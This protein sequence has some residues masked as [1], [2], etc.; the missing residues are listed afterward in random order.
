MIKANDTIFKFYLAMMDAYEEFLSEKYPECNCAED[1]KH[2]QTIIIKKIVRM[3][4]SLELLTKNTL[5]E[6]STRCI[7]RGIL[8]SVT[9]YCFIYQR[10][11]LEDIMFRHYLYTLDG[12]REYKR[13]GIGLSEENEYKKKV[14]YDCD[15]V[16]K[17]IEEKLQ[18]HPYFF[19]YG[20]IV[21]TIIRNANWKFESLQNPRSLKYGEMYEFVGFNSDLTEYYRGYLSQFAHGLCF[22][23]ISSNSEI[24]KTVMYESIVIADKL[25]QAINQTF[26]DKEIINHVLYSDTIQKYLN[27]KDF[28]SA[29]LGEFVSALVRK[30]KTLLI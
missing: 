25:V 7:L 4:H 2:Y 16:I 9:T 13:S 15:Y 11:D 14:E 8:D 24:M 26:R 23:N 6:V 18:N 5:D 17:Q 21:K 20:S 12:W 27:S 1:T 29:E 3:F 30:D 10:K 22:S 19:Q 28:H